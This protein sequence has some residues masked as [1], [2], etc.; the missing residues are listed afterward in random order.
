MFLGFG[1]WPFIQRSLAELATGVCFCGSHSSSCALP[2]CS[3]GLAG[4]P[5][6]PPVGLGAPREGAPEWTVQATEICDTNEGLDL[7]PVPEFRIAFLGSHVDLG[8]WCDPF[9]G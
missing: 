3:H 6:Q 9:R 1:R 4:F 2:K 7:W 8:G 5:S